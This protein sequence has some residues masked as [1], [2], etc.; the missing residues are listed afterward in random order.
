MK[1]VLVGFLWTLVGFLPATAQVVW[2]AAGTGAAVNGLAVSPDGS[3][4]VTAG[5]DGAVRLWRLADGALAKVMG[6][7]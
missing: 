3:T 2:S 6:V 1:F 5:E 7:H 4:A